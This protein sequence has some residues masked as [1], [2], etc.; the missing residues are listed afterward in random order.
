MLFGFCFGFGICFLF[1]YR[2]FVLWL[3]GYTG[4][5]SKPNGCV[6]INGSLCFAFAFA[7][8]VFPRSVCGRCFVAFCCTC[9]P[10]ACCCVVFC[11]DIM[12]T[13]LI[14]FVVS[15]ECLV[16]NGGCNSLTSCVNTNGSFYCTACPTGYDGTGLTSCTPHDYCNPTPCWVQYYPP[17]QATCT[18]TSTAPFYSCKCPTLTG[19]TAVG[20]TCVYHACRSNPNCPVNSQCQGLTIPQ[21]VCNPGFVAYPAGATTP[22]IV[23]CLD[24]NGN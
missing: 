11:N 9:L 12:T 1:R 20:N 24:I 15:S 17:E 7:L 13:T 6:D 22:G 14:V 21:C 16:N 3:L 18:V 5:G 8:N 4:D 23:Q 2:S 19:L 10:V